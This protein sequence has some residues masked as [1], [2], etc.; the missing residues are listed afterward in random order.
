MF[1]SFRVI[2]EKYC[3]N[4]WETYEVK[5]VTM[6]PAARRGAQWHLQIRQ[7]VCLSLYRK[8]MKWITGPNN[9]PWSWPLRQNEGG[10]A[11]SSDAGPWVERTR[12]SSFFFWSRF[13]EQCEKYRQLLNTKNTGA[14]HSLGIKNGHPSLV[15]TISLAVKCLDSNL[16]HFWRPK[17]WNTQE[18]ASKIRRATSLLNI[19]STC[20]SE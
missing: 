12:P 5:S 16:L 19:A 9:S 15:H 2:Y 1:E 20:P 7:T 3:V 17:G 10:V 6:H 13:V 8:G 4:K 14:T 11:M 18:I